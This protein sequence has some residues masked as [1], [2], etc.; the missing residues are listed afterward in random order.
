MHPLHAAPA[1]LQ[2]SQAHK[3]AAAL[4]I[5]G[6]YDPIDGLMLPSDLTARMFG[7][8]FTLVTELNPPAP[9]H[10][11]FTVATWNAWR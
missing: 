4:F 1:P 5:E 8:H 10:F 6:R 11:S 9:S 2:R 3:P 7:T